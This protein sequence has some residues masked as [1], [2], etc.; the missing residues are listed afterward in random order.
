MFANKVSLH[1]VNF[2]AMKFVFAEM[3]SKKRFVIISRHET[4]FLTVDLIGD[5]QA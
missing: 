5:F 2:A 3:R 4:D 1:I